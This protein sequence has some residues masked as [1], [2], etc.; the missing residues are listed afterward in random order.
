MSKK[1]M[2][3]VILLGKAIN[4]PANAEMTINKAGNSTKWYVDN[5]E[6]LIGIGKDHTATLIMDKDSH[7]ALIN[8]EKVQINEG[9]PTK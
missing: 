9:D 5:I 4:I 6:I 3:E 7:A 1:R 8:G 2:R